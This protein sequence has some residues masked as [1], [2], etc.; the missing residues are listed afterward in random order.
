MR[1]DSDDNEPEPK[2]VRRGRP[3]TKN[4]KKTLGRPSLERAGSEFSADA[5][6]ATGGE[7]NWSN[8]LRKG[9]H[10]SDKS[11]LADSSG[12]F[13]GSRNNDVYTNWMVDNKSERND[14]FPGLKLSIGLLLVVHSLQFS[15]FDV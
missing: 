13:L 2:I 5:T 4:L 14:E 15:R 11:A 10:L 6:L 9:T 8:D 3:P 12:R 7:N 1:Q